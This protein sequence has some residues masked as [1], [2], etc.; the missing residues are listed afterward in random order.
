M[1]KRWRKIMLFVILPIMVIGSFL[2]W[3]TWSGSTD[4][5]ERVADQFKVPSTWTLV[6]SS[7]EP[8][9]TICLTSCPR[10][11]RTWKVT[12]A[13][14]HDQFDTILEQS[15]WSAVTLDQRCL[16]ENIEDSPKASCGANGEVEGY[17]VSIYIVKGYFTDTTDGV[18]RVSLYLSNST[19]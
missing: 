16:P 15:G 6:D 18:S 10:L 11:S 19:R 7:A 13:I 17:D 1:S 3:A 2:Y 14:T 9:Q 12:E 5:I 4:D 8:P